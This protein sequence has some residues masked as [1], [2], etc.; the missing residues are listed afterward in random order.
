MYHI[1]LI[2]W[3]NLAISISNIRDNGRTIHEKGYKKETE[4]KA[5]YIGFLFVP[6][7]DKVLTILLILGIL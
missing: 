2:M 7:F 3:H 1:M 5:F 4:N 6:F